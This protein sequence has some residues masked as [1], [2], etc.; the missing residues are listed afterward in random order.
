MSESIVQPLTQG[1]ASSAIA[2]VVTGLVSL[3]A[4]ICVLLPVLW[5]G[6][7]S[8]LFKSA[9]QD[10]T[11]VW[12]FF[13]TPLGWYTASLLIGTAIT[14][15]HGLLETKWISAKAISRGLSNCQTQA[16]FEQ[17]GTFATSYFTVCIAIHGFNSLVLRKRFPVWASVIYTLL[18]WASSIITGLV[19]PMLNR[20]GSG[21]VYGDNGYACSITREYPLLEFVFQLLPIIATALVSAVLY[22]VMFLVL[23]GTIQVKGGISLN[24]D[25]NIRWT[26]IGTDS[27]EYQRFIGAIVRSMILYPFAYTLLMMPLC[28][29][30]LITMSKNPV[31]FGAGIFASSCR[32]LLGL[33]DALIVYKILR[34]LRPVIDASNVRRYES[35]ESFS[36]PELKPSPVEP[37]QRPPITP[38]RAFPPPRKSA[39]GRPT[40]SIRTMPSTVSLNGSDTGS[41]YPLLPEQPFMHAH[42]RSTSSGLSSVTGAISRP[43]TPVSE[44]NRAL[45][46][47]SPIAR[48]EAMKSASAT[49]YTISRYPTLAIKKS[50]ESLG[51]PPPP[52]PSRSPVT[53]KPPPIFTP[54]PDAGADD[55][56]ATKS[57]IQQGPLQWTSGYVDKSQDPPAMSLNA[58]RIDFSS[59]PS[60]SAVTAP[61][62]TIA[63][64]RTQSSD[65]DAGRLPV[66]NEGKLSSV[67]WATLVANAA[68]KDV[69]GMTL[70]SLGN[71]RRDP[72]VPLDVSPPVPFVLR[73]GT[74]SFA[75]PDFSFPSFGQ[76]GRDR[77][78]STSSSSS[79][80]IGGRTMT[81]EPRL[82]PELR[83]TQ[84]DALA[85]RQDS[86]VSRAATPAYF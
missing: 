26:G 66:D 62:E 84:R 10:R 13:S 52:R 38:A 6:A 83:E 72:D 12:M 42:T 8:M 39:D 44:L 75:N 23:R 85:V 25:P 16:A 82:H 49:P 80:S 11:K 33:V 9:S 5:E 14:D 43:I 4:A 60:V 21:L 65:T 36:A 32:L 57:A 2:L 35:Q 40:P 17:I 73:P 41:T 59:R 19:V 31:S 70:S 58:A 53:R 47:P 48:P 29:V 86:V 50:S 22:A 15:V 77:Q 18:G 81:P 46:G 74:P 67:A 76:G 28:F 71:D 34:V 68:T 27:A 63:D 30:R 54:E 7:R 1:Q 24:L 3:L 45:A 61:A 20:P 51:L 56:T 78:A 79:S 64:N 55:N 69:G 37:A